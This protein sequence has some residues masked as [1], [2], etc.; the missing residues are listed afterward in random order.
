[1]VDG[2]SVF[3]SFFSLVFVANFG[4]SARVACWNIEEIVPAPVV[5]AWF[6]RDGSGAAATKNDRL[7]AWLTESK[8]MFELSV[9]VW[10]VFYEI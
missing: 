9:A 4:E 3:A 7:F 8:A 1:L 10:L 5:A 6:F 2:V